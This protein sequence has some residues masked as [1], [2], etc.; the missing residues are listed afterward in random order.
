MGQD[1]RLARERVGYF[2][3]W[4]GYFGG[5]VAWT[6]MHLVS[7]LWASVACGTRAEILLHSTTVVTSLVTIA[8]I[9]VCYG[10][11][12]MLQDLEPRSP[13]VFRFML[14]SGLFL[15]LIFL[16]TILATVST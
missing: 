14:Y 9:W 7:Y 6:V 12:K 2:R 11:L 16:L 1:I 15:N 10:N 13:G 3:L 5:A 4:F 8:A